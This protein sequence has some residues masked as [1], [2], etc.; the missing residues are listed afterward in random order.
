M[1]RPCRRHSKN[2]LGRSLGQG[3][4]QLQSS[5]AMQTLHTN[6]S[7]S[8]SLYLPFPVWSTPCAEECRAKALQAAPPQVQL[9]PHQNDTHN[10]PSH[11][12][13]FDT[14][15]PLDDTPTPLLSLVLFYRGVPC[16]GSA[17]SQAAPQVQPP[18]HQHE[19]HSS[20]SRG[21]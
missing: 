14:P 17:G 19:T 6:T 2:T 4:F 11:T 16:K 12:S 10:T 21:S 15:P 3:P 13:P 5:A 18:T 1:T 7:Q 20:N 9:C 8:L